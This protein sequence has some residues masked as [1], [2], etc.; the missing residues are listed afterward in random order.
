MI[1]M[2][3]KKK[4]HFLRENRI[5]VLQNAPANGLNAAT[6][7]SGCVGCKQKGKLK[8]HIPLAI[9]KHSTPCNNT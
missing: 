6:K 4:N 2:S 7:T 8:L 9:L 5:T 1:C 3:K